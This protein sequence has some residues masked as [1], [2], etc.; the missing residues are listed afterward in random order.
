MRPGRKRFTG[1]LDVFVFNP[2]IS[3]ATFDYNWR[4]QAVSAGWDQIKP[5][6]TTLTLNSGGSISS[7]VN[8]GT[9]LTLNAL[10]SGSIAR[11]NIA[12]GCFI[13]GPTGTGGAGGAASSQLNTGG[14]GGTGGRAI[15]VSHSTSI[16]N[17]G[18]IQGGSGGGGGGGNAVASAA[19]P[20]LS[21]AG[22]RG[23]G[24]DGAAL[25]GNTDS[26]NGRSATG[27]T[28]GNEGIGG[29][30]G[31]SSDAP[32]PAPGGAAGAQGS[33]IQGLSNVTYINR[34]TVSGPEI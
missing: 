17:F 31:S 25:A 28:G 13:R 16:E 22:G 24:I 29:G 8:G 20:Q 15:V 21:G 23:G 32:G 3:T 5:L 19:G 9:A 26:F 4:A 27:G 34:G 30:T 14:T 11:L 2:V 12:S 1:G 18:T 7:V 6:Y 33:A 10:T